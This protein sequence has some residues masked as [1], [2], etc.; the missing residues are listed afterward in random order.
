MPRRFQTILRALLVQLGGLSFAV[1]VVVL[2]IAV[3][4]LKFGQIGVG[5][6]RTVTL[7]GSPSMTSFQYKWP[8]GKPVVDSQGRPIPERIAEGINTATLPWPRFWK[9]HGIRSGFMWSR[10]TS[11]WNWT[12]LS[13]TEGGHWLAK[14]PPTTRLEYFEV[15][16]P[17]W[18]VLLITGVPPL[19]YFLG[20][21]R[22]LR[23]RRYRIKH[24]LCLACGY[25]LRA[26]PVRCPECGLEAR[27]RDRT[28]KTGGRFFSACANMMP[29]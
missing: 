15:G 3:G 1:A 17:T 27:R 4:N 24:G 25:D 19:W 26:T 5:G 8:G 6:Y 9:G 14:N 16:A 23:I 29:L 10:R 18:L 21:Y 28:A 13:G 2:V 12:S 20:P 7:R 11:G 22:R